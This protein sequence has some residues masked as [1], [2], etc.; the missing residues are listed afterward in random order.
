MSTKYGASLS[1]LRA[2]TCSGSRLAFAASSPVMY[3]SAAIAWSTTLRRSTA[4]FG[5]ANG[6]RRAGL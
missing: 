6:E 3:C 1:T 2:T 5:L 4:G